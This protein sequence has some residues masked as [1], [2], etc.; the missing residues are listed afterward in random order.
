MRVLARGTRDP[1][2]RAGDWSAGNA[3]DDPT[4]NAERSFQPNIDDSFVSGGVGGSGVGL[5]NPGEGTVP[6]EKVVG[7]FAVGGVAD[8]GLAL[9]VGHRQG[10]PGVAVGSEKD[11]GRRRTVGPADSK[12]DTRVG[13]QNEGGSP[14]LRRRRLDRET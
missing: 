13:R 9:F 7:E 2:R 10:R 14:R 12:P 6:A 1:D 3:V 4:W 5:G 8:D 11:T